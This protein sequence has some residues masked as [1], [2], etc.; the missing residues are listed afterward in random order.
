MV[1][2]NADRKERTIFF[3]WKPVHNMQTTP[4]STLVT[5]SVKAGI[6]RLQFAG[7]WAIQVG[8]YTW[9]L[10]QGNHQIQLGKD[11]AGPVEWTELF[12]LTS[13]RRQVVERKPIE[14]KTQKCGTTTKT[15]VEINDIARELILDL[16]SG[17]LSLLQWLAQT[18]VKV[19]QAIFGKRLTAL[20]Y[21]GPQ[22]ALQIGLFNLIRGRG[23]KDKGDEA[24][25]YMYDVFFRNYHAFCERLALRICTSRFRTRFFF[26]RKM[27][28]Q[29]FLF[30]QLTLNA[31]PPGLHV[32]LQID[33]QVMLQGIQL[34][35]MIQTI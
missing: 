32:A 8:D 3:K 9:E 23:S 19:G 25:Q 13:D 7:H 35:T 27:N 33:Q 29:K 21:A 4:D 31:H 28:G 2:T 22:Q 12:I 34:Q 16:Q 6:R 11:D 24:Q 18:Q 17:K 20:T 5:K 1:E 30:S 26:L 15:D 14:V 10:A